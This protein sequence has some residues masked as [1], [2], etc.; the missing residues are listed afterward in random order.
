MKI[1][2]YLHA[3]DTG[4]TEQLHKSPTSYHEVAI[5]FSSFCGVDIRLY[6]FRLIQRILT[7]IFAQM[8]SDCYAQPLSW[9]L[10][11]QTKLL[12]STDDALH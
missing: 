11:Q 3:S 8:T 10:A 4:Y 12:S 6:A 5:P 2:G 7:S 1:S 9:D